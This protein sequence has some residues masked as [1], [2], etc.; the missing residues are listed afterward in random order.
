MSE[1]NNND[2][3]NLIDLGEEKGGGG[4][5][6]I[7]PPPVDLLQ[8]LEEPPPY[9]PRLDMDGPLEGEEEGEEEINPFEV[10]DNDYLDGGGKYDFNMDAHFRFDNSGSLSKGKDK[11]PVR[12]AESPMQVPSPPGGGRMPGTGYGGD[13]ALPGFD[14]SELWKRIEVL[15]RENLSLREERKDLR[16][17]LAKKNNSNASP[18][19]VVRDINLGRPYTL[20]HVRNLQDKIELI[21]YAV[22]SRVGSTIVLVVLFLK[23]T[24][25]PDI[26]VRLLKDRPRATFSYVKHLK[27]TFDW[28]ALVEIYRDLG[29]TYEEGMLMYRRSFFRKNPK[30]R[31]TA[32]NTCKRFFKNN[33]KTVF[34]WEA[35]QVADHAGLLDRQII[36]ETNDVQE[37]RKG[38]EIYTQCPREGR[39]I[40][41]STLAA[42]VEWSCLYRY[43]Y[44][45]ILVTSPRTLK[46]DFKLTDK[47]YAYYV[48]NGRSKARDWAGIEDFF[49]WKGWVRANR[50]QSCIGFEPIIVTLHKY[51]APV[52]A[53]A[54]YIKMLDNLEQKVLWSYK[55]QTH[56][57]AIEVLKELKDRSSLNEYRGLVAAQW[58]L[59]DVLK[60][61]YILKI[62]LLLADDTIAWI[63]V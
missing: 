34:K 13:G 57:V 42:S 27:N 6:A 30:E 52:D 15:K 49:T 21:D 17:Q 12:P 50:L 25:S 39:S 60:S 26:F 23:N 16:V 35:D 63:E 33:S 7:L 53:L 31:F 24:L 1:K 11:S 29:W 9:V 51:R 28:P 44:D 61:D 14:S 54:K 4:G 48:L 22:E 56:D 37:E 2:N 40:L 43:S 3:N 18:F 36:M 55:Y 47:Q 59:V 32:L 5:G 38:K 46:E 62:D 41:F 20:E 19:D 58:T 10:T 45:D 8:G